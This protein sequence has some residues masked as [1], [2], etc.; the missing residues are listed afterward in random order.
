MTNSIAIVLALLVA[1]LF[2]LDAT[3]LH[4]GLPVLIGKQ[5]D[6]LVEWAALE[7]AWAQRDHVHYTARAYQRLGEV[8][9][10]SLLS[11]YDGPMPMMAASTPSEPATTATD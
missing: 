2:L 10:G 8:L 5:F 9:H 3:V 6:S 11:G 1:G 4:L 7:P